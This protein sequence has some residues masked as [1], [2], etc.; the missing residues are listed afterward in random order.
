MKT[1]SRTIRIEQIK[2]G[3]SRVWWVI[4]A[5]VIVIQPLMALIAAK[6]FVKIGLDATPETHPELAQ[7][8]PPLDYLGFS[9]LTGNLPMVIFG[10]MIGASEYKNHQLRTTLLCQ[11]S[12]I[13]V[14]WA[15]VLA[16]LICSVFISLLT[17]YAT[18]SITHVGLGELGLHPFYLSTIAWQFIGFSAL[19][20]ILLTIL[21][22][23]IGMLFKNA[24]V[25]LAF[26][27]PQLYNLGGYLAQRWEW[28]EYLP[29]AA[30][31]FLIAR[32]TDP[33]EHDPLQG[34][35]VLLVWVILTL[36]ISYYAFTRN[37]VGGK[38]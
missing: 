24:L 11:S 3:S 25:P 4:C 7:A 21:S 18:I 26:L 2:I 15:K 10:G 22:F 37:D 23:G 9:S 20:W 14:F 30:G 19:N 27:V 33:F 28:A 17:I 38:Y 34:G 6:S 5:L 13:K 32:P 31:N 1:F 12:R 36:I 16:L 8:L 29:V 35:I